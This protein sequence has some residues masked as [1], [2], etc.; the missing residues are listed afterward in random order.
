[1]DNDYPK[2]GDPNFSFIDD[3]KRRLGNAKDIMLEP[4]QQLPEGDYS[5]LPNE[6]MA[7]QGLGKLFR[8]Y[9]AVLPDPV[10]VAPEGME[11][12]YMDTTG[13]MGTVKFP[14][15]GKALGNVAAET[16]AVEPVIKEAGP[17]MKK[18]GSAVGNELPSDMSLLDRI[19]LA[20]E[21]SGPIRQVETFEQA[22]N[23]KEMD[24]LKNLPKDYFDRARR[25]ANENS[26]QKNQESVQRILDNYK[27]DPE[28]YEQLKKMMLGGE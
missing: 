22:V 4:P 9:Q 8:A 23:S 17:M 20:K 27:N 11:P 12:R 10:N 19:K 28:K 6:Y 3:M 2:Y 26:L 18:Y 15:L 7:G 24:R 13:F 25:I 21:R 16:K 1:M 14:K 5:M